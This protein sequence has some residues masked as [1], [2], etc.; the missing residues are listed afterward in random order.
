MELI[1]EDTDIQSL[2]AQEPLF[3]EGDKGEVRIYM[4]T[5]MSESAIGQLTKELTDKGVVLTGPIS[6]ESRMLSIKFEKRILPL[7][8]IAI[9]V[10]GVLGPGFLGW[11]LF[12]PSWGAPLGI[13]M[14]VWVAGAALIGLL[15]YMGVKR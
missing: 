9:A 6:Y 5:E 10:V 2:A 12:K 7:V 8:P 14:G 1:A 4:S 15:F 13:S 11:Q 3:Q